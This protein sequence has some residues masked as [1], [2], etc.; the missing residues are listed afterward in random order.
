MRDLLNRATTD[1]SLLDRKAVFAFIYTA[2]GLTAIF[3]LKNPDTVTW[4]LSGA[5]F[6]HLGEYIARS[7]ANNLPE[8]GWWAVVVTI[9]YFVIPAACIKLL[10]GETL[11]DYGLNLRIETG[12]GKLFASTAALALPLVYLM[13]L[14][15]S[16]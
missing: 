13:S 1:F 14:T 4:F 11:A 12:F 6:E 16:F 10:Y 2:V 3:Y 7:P 9:F 5:R 8:L 15:E